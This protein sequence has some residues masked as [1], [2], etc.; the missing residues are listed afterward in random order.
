VDVRDETAA[1]QPAPEP[2]S[3]R[4]SHSPDVGRLADWDQQLSVIAEEAIDLQQELSRLREES[5][6]V[7]QLLEQRE[8]ELEEKTALLMQLTGE[9][10]QTEKSMTAANASLSEAQT[11][12]RQDRERIASL[13][14]LLE[15]R[16]AELE[17]ATALEKELHSLR[18]HVAGLGELESRGAAMPPQPRSHLRLVALP[19]G[20]ELSESAEL[21]PPVGELIEIDGRQYAVASRGRSPLP[22][23]E[24]P[25]VLLL[26]EPSG[27]EQSR[28]P[29]AFEPAADPIASL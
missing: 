24:R 28:S 26:V 10:D 9:R 2:G 8:C 23:D 22:G 20:Y 14:Q 1:S 16:Q 18:A 27:T 21:P 25:C 3:D 6:A 13:E 12:V 19:T 7:V 4:T 5:E 15:L 29:D 11:R 17:R